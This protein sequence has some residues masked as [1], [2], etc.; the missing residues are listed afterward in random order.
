VLIGDSLKD[1]QALRELAQTP[2]VSPQLLVPVFTPPDFPDFYGRRAELE[3]IE[4][5]VQAISVLVMWGESGV[6]KTYLGAQLAKQLSKDYKV[7]W[8]DREGL[9][10][11]ELLLQVNEF[12]KANGEYGFVTTYAED[13]ITSKNKIP[14]LVQIISTSKVAK[15]AFFLDGFQLANHSE[16]K[17]FIER[18]RTYGGKSRVVLI[19]HSPD[20]RLSIPERL[21]CSF[22]GLQSD[23]HSCPDRCKLRQHILSGVL[24][25]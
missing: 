15:Y 5:L 1:D 3:Q 20:C 2:L 23:T 9:T 6:G 12:L 4:R 14:A 11:D 13:K 17:P 25:L 19:D 8:L 7:C 16:I 10:L 21:S 18:F 22:E 24:I